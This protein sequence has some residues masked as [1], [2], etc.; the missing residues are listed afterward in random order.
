M[1]KAYTKDGDRYSGTTTDNFDRKFQLFI[2]RCDEVD[3]SEEDGH[4][5]LSIL[6]IN[7]A[8]KLPSTSCHRKI[9]IFLSLA[10]G[11][12]E[13]L[14]PTE[15]T[16]AFPLEQEGLILKD[17]IT[18][19][20]E[21]TPFAILELF[22]AKLTDTQRAL[23]KEFRS[24]T[25]L[26]IDILLTDKSA[27]TWIPG[28]VRSS[29][30]LT[31]LRLARPY[32]PTDQERPFWKARSRCSA[33]LARTISFYYLI[34]PYHQSSDLPSSRCLLK[35]PLGTILMTPIPEILEAFHQT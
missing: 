6:L 33:S 12:R 13:R 23:P 24:D 32:S 27:M 25:I 14:K 34:P 20:R 35:T 28:K 10:K 4:R 18:T 7:N 15:R 17:V 21:K 1:F 19:N 26:R 30:T 16:R 2:E 8:F 11:V 31:Q 29:P 5:A 3:I 9:R 22:I